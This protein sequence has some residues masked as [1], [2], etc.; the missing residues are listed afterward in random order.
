[1]AEAA[2]VPSKADGNGEASAE[3]CKV[4]DIMKALQTL[5]NTVKEMR[6]GMNFAVHHV[7]EN[8]IQYKDIDYKGNVA[9]HISDGFYHFAKVEEIEHLVS[10]HCPHLLKPLA[11]PFT[12]IWNNLSSYMER[13]IDLNW[14]FQKQSGSDKAWL[15][16]AE[17]DTRD[18]L[19][20]ANHMVDFHGGEFGLLL[21]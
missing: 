7:A 19:K 2:D 3:L 13:L 21:L 16:R 5:Y 14:Q 8:K 12:R 18:G 6:N 10:L 15:E 11:K 17:H 1:M 20:H 9:K 4:E